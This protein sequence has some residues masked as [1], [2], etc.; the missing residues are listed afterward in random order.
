MKPIMR[1]KRYN[2]TKNLHIETKKWF[3]QAKIAST[4][5]I[6]E[7]ESTGTY[8]LPL[9][10]ASSAFPLAIGECRHI[11]HPSSGLHPGL[12]PFLLPLLQPLSAVA[13]AF[14]LYIFDKKECLFLTNQY[15][16]GFQLYL[17]ILFH[18]RKKAIMGQPWGYMQQDTNK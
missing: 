18:R 16:G 13:R 14:L 4:A 8:L 1:A 3:F 11:P 7:Y 10:P 6:F 2:N 15:Y 17:L 9:P 5:P 12:G